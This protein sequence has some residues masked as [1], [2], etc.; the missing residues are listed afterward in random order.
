MAQA[1]ASY[2]GGA[3]I[4]LVEDAARPEAARPT[5]TMVKRHRLTSLSAAKRRLRQQR[6]RLIRGFDVASL[7]ISA[8]AEHR[9]L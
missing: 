4:G 1:F 7:S 6:V 9:R 5:T 8:S 2:L 3:G